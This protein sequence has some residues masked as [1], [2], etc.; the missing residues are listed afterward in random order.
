MR[1]RDTFRHP[2]YRHNCAQCIAMKYRSLYPGEDVMSRFQN[3]AGGRA[4][5]GL[6]GALY[7]MLTAYPERAEELK[8]RFAEQTH[9]L[10]T[11]RELKGVGGVACQTCVD[12]VDDMMESLGAK[13]G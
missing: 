5:G 7:A 6:C 8:S 3:S 2:A 1:A 13:N 10:T 9:G 4:E 12:I 11:C